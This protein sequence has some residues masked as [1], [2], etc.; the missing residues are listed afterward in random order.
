MKPA[1][2]DR[3]MEKDANHLLATTDR[4]NSNGLLELNSSTV[5]SGAAT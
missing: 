1:S 3:I 2:V 4:V 5:T